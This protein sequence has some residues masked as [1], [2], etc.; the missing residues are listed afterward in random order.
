MKK[1]SFTIILSRYF[2][3]MLT[4][5]DESTK[6]EVELKDIVDSQIMALS[7]HFLYNNNLVPLKRKNVHDILQLAI[8]LQIQSLQGI[9]CKYLQVSTTF[10]IFPLCI[11]T[12][13]HIQK[14]KKWQFQKYFSRSYPILIHTLVL[15][16]MFLC[17]QIVIIKMHERR[18]N[19][20]KNTY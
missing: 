5:F 12:F 16:I 9:C 6:S 17:L 3:T 4:M 2:E 1:I 20:S 15:Q 19:N 7:L 14:I 10:C 11:P 18:K 8:Y 13:F